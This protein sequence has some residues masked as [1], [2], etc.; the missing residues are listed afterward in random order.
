MRINE[1][2][3]LDGVR[4]VAELMCVAARTAPKGRG[5]DEIVTAIVEDIREREQV[6]ERMRE[7]GERCGAEFFTRDAQN[8][9]DAQILVL[10]GTGLRR[11]RLP[12][13]GLCGFPDCDASEEAGARCAFN[14]GDLG[15]ATGSAVS[16]AADHRVDNRV[17][18][19]A[20]RAAVELGVLGE[21]VEI[22]WGIP[23]S[24]KGKN[25]FFDRK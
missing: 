14:A 25:L 21:G 16:V 23:L 3:E 15:I 10:L 8:V 1:E 19:T 24:A 6:A 22:A 9:L 17:M 5:V 20:G 12:E 7:I 13:C 4:R 11:M 18:F 2:A